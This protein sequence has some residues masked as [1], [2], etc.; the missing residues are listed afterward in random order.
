M[1]AEI[2]KNPGK[3]EDGKDASDD[4]GCFFHLSPI[5]A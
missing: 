1:N 4:K 2:Q 3:K 5:M